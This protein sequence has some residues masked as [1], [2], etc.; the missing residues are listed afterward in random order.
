MYLY[1]YA[2]FL[3]AKKYAR[4]LALIEGRIT[5][6]G[7]GGKISQLSQFLKFPAAI[8]EFGLKRLKTLVVVGDD[9][10]LEE[11]VSAF[12]CSAVAVGFVPFGESR[13]AQTLG[14]SSGS[15]AIDII[16]ARRIKKCDAAMIGKEY[17]FGSIECEG[18][19]IEVHTPQFS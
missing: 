14:I 1:L 13:Y 10:L 11:A 8:R 2:P 5:D 3:R 9:A 18:A 6:F 17:I 19:G 16:A 7:I 12:A 4:E 15:K